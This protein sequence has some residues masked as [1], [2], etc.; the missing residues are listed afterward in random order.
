MGLRALDAE[1][2]RELLLLI[3]PARYA[4]IIFWQEAFVVPATA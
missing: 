2:I 3:C 4:M 1:T